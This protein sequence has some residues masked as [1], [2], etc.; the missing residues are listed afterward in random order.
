MVSVL[1]QGECN[2]RRLEREMDADDAPAPFAFN[3]PTAVASVV[4][5]LVAVLAS[6]GGIGGGGVFVPLLML[7][8]GLGGKWAGEGGSPPHLLKLPSIPTW[9]IS[10]ILDLVTSWRFTPS[11]TCTMVPAACARLLCFQ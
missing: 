1:Y 9:N 10:I 5:F 8:V 11:V 6:V 3:G 7:V 4:C 2:R